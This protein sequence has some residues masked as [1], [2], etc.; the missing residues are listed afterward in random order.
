MGPLPT[1]T[2]NFD[3][4]SNIQITDSTNS[5]PAVAFLTA[6][7]RT[8]KSSVAADRTPMMKP[9]PS[10]LVVPPKRQIAMH[11]ATKGNDFGESPNKFGSNPQYNMPVSSSAYRKALSSNQGRISSNAGAQLQAPQ[12]SQVLIDTPSSME[13]AANL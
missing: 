7:T 3:L 11:N 1:T 8:S 2:L 12:F 6:G 9:I 4:S 10:T 13:Q 5:G